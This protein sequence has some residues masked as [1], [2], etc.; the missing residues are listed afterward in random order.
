MSDFSKPVHESYVSLCRELRL[1]RDWHV[2]DWFAWL[3]LDLTVDYVGLWDHDAEEPYDPESRPPPER[4][5]VWLPSLSDWLEML[6]KGGHPRSGWNH[7]SFHWLPFPDGST[8]GRHAPCWTAN[9]LTTANRALW[10]GIGP[11]REE[12]CARLWMAVT[13]PADPKS[14]SGK[15]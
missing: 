11:T 13:K 3:E 4:R 2:G 6:E 5:R 9:T 15:D 12:A 10:Y 7:I 14:T 8:E 1:E